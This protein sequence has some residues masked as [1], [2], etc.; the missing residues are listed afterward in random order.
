MLVIFVYN[1]PVNKKE[2]KTMDTKF[3]NVQTVFA[4]ATELLGRLY[5]R[6]KE[7]KYPERDS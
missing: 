3:V 2:T 7:T 1:L 5:D 6:L 4:Q